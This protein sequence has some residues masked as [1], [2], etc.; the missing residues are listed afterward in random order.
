MTSVSPAVCTVSRQSKF[1]SKVQRS[2]ESQKNRWNA[3]SSLTYAS[4]SSDHEHSFIKTV[5]AAGAALYASDVI[6]DLLAQTPA[7]NVLKSKFKGLADI[8]LTEAKRQGCSYADV[9][10]TMTPGWAAARPTSRP[11]RRPRWRR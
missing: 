4:T 7:G 11:R 8:V 3:L 6:A 1:R 9:R 2:N 10:F 5:G